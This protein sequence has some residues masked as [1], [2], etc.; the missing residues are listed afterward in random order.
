M[1]LPLNSCSDSD[2]V[3]LPWDTFTCMRHGLCMIAIPS[4][5]HLHRLLSE[6]VWVISLRPL[7][8]PCFPASWLSPSL[9]VHP[10]EAS[11]GHGGW[12]TQC[13]RAASWKCPYSHTWLMAKLNNK[14]QMEH[15]FP[16]ECWW[17]CFK[18]F[19][20]QLLLG[21][22]ISP[23]WRLFILVSEARGLGAGAGLFPLTMLGTG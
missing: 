6:P 4:W 11:W 9:D 1:Y 10:P 7:L 17:P 19:Q 12:E 2:K 16:S 8:D 5:D 3:Q 15:L 21:S 20:R 18:A 23:P 22:G 13:F 14:Q